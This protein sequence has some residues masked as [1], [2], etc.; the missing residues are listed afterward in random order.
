[1]WT[2]DGELVFA[3]RADTQVKV[4]GYR[5]EPGEV[6]AALTGHPAVAQAVVV[7]REDR[8]GERRLIGYVVPDGTAVDGEAVR[9]HVAGLLPDYLVPAAVVVLDAL[10]VTANGKVDRAAL[11]APD[12]AARAGGRAPR[13]AAEETLCALFAEVLG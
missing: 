2:D 9:D 6:E 4:R 3:G 12:F 8:P 7:A 10:P 11:P 5:V 1:H 13:N